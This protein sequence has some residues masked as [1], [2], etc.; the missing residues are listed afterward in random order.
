MNM[1]WSEVNTL[2]ESDDPEKA[3]NLF[4]KIYSSIFDEKFPLTIHKSSYKSI[5]RTAWI[6]KGLI[7]CCNKKLHL[8][9]KYIKSRS[10]EA[11]QKSATMM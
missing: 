7:K 6:S 5:P 1:N 10:N 2:S 11:K 3:Y 9:K 4:L 8:Y